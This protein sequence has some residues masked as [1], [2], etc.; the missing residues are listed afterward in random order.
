MSKL[1]FV[2]I[3]LLVLGIAAECVLFTLPPFELSAPPGTLWYL[4]FPHQPVQSAAIVA[5][6]GGICLKISL[7]QRKGRQ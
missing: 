1:R 3:L 2:G 4:A 5:L 7:R 6:I